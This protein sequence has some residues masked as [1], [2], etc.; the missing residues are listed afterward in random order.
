MTDLFE[1]AKSNRSTCK[2][3]SEKIAKGEIRFGLETSFNRGGTLLINH[4]W[5]H[6]DCAMTKYKRKIAKISDLSPLDRLQKEI[7]LKIKEKNKVSDFQPKNI[8]ELTGDDAI[9]NVEGR[10]LRST[11]PRELEKPNGEFEQGRV[12]YVI[13][14]LDKRGKVV[15]WKD[16]DTH[17]DNADKIIIIN[18]MTVIG[19]DESVEVHH[20]GESKLYINEEPEVILGIEK[21]MS[22]AWSRPLESQ[23]VFTIAPSSRATCVICEK[24]IKKGELK[25]V[26]PVWGI[27]EVTEDRY[28]GMQSLHL[29]CSNEDEHSGELL[30][31]A[32]SCLNPQIVNEN[33]GTLNEFA[34]KIKD[35]EA[36]NQLGEL[37]K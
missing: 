33:R 10:I 19:N 32:I 21:Y 23:A 29:N 37:V 8:S 36:K 20:E 17:L 15:L 13:D 35:E 28:P 25:L 4:K 30:K 3:C 22:Q 24:G 9:V 5:H 14:K 27:N 26:K 34:E 1:N 7:V 16:L 6:F 2:I 18:G 11:K 31:E 12:L